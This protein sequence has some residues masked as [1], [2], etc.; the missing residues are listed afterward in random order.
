ML[1]RHGISLIFAVCAAATCLAA[2]AQQQSGPPTAEQAAPT[3][4]RPAE[5]PQAG[6]GA[7]GQP[8]GEPAQH[9]PSGAQTPSA[10]FSA[11]LVTTADASWQ[12][13]WAVPSPTAPDFKQVNAVH[14]G[15]HIY[16]LIFMSNPSLNAMEQVDVRCDLRVTAPNGVRSVQSDDMDC[17]TGKLNGDLGSVW[18]SRHVLEFVGEPADPIGTWRVDVT[19]RDLPRNKSVNLHTTFELLEGS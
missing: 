14:R 6:Q 10:E 13:R 4:A 18:L 9:P 15:E 2:A 5:T 12:K 16:T 8:D 7:T 19:L 1:P 11:W 3:E 17:L